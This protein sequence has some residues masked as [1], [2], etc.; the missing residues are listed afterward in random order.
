MKTILIL[1][2]LVFLNLL[3]D[4]PNPPWLQAED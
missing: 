1:A 3:G 2:S 4:Q